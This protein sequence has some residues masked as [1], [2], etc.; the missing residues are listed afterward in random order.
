M[1]ETIADNKHVEEPLTSKVTSSVIII[2]FTS[3]TD[4]M[5][6]DGPTTGETFSF[7]TKTATTFE[8]KTLWKDAYSALQE[9]YKDRSLCD[10]TLIAGTTTIP[11]HRLVL[12]TCSPYFRAMFT[13]EMR[14]SRQDAVRLNDIDEQ[15]LELLVNFMYTSKIVL[16]VENVQKLLFSASLLQI[17][18]ISKACS[19]FMKCH[20]DPTNCFGV[21]SF[22]EQHGRM[23]LKEAAQRFCFEHFVAL[24]EH[25]EFVLMDF[26]HMHSLISSPDIVIDDEKQVYNSIIRWIRHDAPYR[27]KYLPELLQEIRLPRMSP[28]FLTEVVES[29]DM[30]KKNHQCRDLV[31]EAKNYHLTVNRLIPESPKLLKN[32][33]RMV[34]RK[35]TAGVLFVIGG[36]GSSGDPFKSTEC[37]DLRNSRWFSVADMTTKRRHVGVTVANGKVYAVGG[38]DGKEHLNTMEVF[39]PHSNKWSP[40]TPMNKCRRGLGVI[41]LGGPIYAIGGLDDSSCFSDVER[42]DPA[43]NSWNSVQAMRSARGGVAVAILNGLIYAIGGNDGSS[44]LNS[45]ERYD[46][47]LN[48]WHEIAPMKMRRAGGGAVVLNGFLYAIGGFDHSAPLNSVERYDPQK[49]E[50]IVVNPMTTCRGGV[51]AAVLAGKLY[52]IGGH[53]GTNYLSSAECYCPYTNSWEIVTS[54]SN[55]RAGAGVAT[56]DCL[57]S[58]LKLKEPGNAN[59]VSCV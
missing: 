22:A 53:D 56:C 37:F 46:P 58:S 25:E 16:T 44:T 38:F 59:L 50:W 28:T 43:S 1:S 12:A 51:G 49:N 40:A 5:A 26:R 36:R 57:V 11:C 3:R 20:L 24:S 41:K 21:L 35:S 47:Y 9:M 4:S 15:C 34:P 19:E 7:S 8:C 6:M 30:I 2:E 18:V 33:S 54:I 52:A 10:V 27:E 13:T 45:C 17:E 48:K 23:E 29:E 31:D 14:E 32:N 39:D 42:Y 55:C